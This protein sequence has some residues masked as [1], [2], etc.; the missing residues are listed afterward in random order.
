MVG[1]RF[2]IAMIWQCGLAGAVSSAK[3][4]FASPVTLKWMEGITGSV[5]I[6]LSSKLLVNDQN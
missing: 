1:I 2:V 4:F 5:L 3:R 6:F